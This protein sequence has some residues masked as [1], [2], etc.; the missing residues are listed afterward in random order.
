MKTTTRPAMHDVILVA[1]CIVGLGSSVFEWPLRVRDLVTAI[2]FSVLIG[3]AATTAVLKYQGVIQVQQASS[4]DTNKLRMRQTVI[5][6][7][8]IVTIAGVI[9][10]QVTI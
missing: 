5:L 6:A 1:A 2:V 8:L 9:I 4:A 3:V 7:G 10:W